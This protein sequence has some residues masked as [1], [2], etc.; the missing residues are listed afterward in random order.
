MTDPAAVTGIDFGG[1]RV[2]AFE[3]RKAEEIRRLIL[4]FG[5]EPM[6]APSM[7]EVALTDQHEALAFA[8]RL[9]EGSLDVV[10]LLTG[11]GTRTLIAALATR[12]PKEQ[13]IQALGRV[14]DPRIDERF[15]KPR[16]R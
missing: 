10:I 7:R 5:G 14:S 3:S 16:T 2:V 12:Y 15:R 13:I 4:R 6:V 8:A 11:V 9:F 1:L